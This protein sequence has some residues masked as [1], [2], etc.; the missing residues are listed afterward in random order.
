[1]G[2]NDL[3]AHFMNEG[4]ALYFPC[5][6][7]NTS[8]ISHAGPKADIDLD[9]KY[10]KAGKSANLSVKEENMYA[11]A[12]ALWDV[13]K[14]IGP[15]VLDP[16]IVKSWR[17]MPV[18]KSGDFVVDAMVALVQADKQMYHGEHNQTIISVF[19]KHNIIC[20]TCK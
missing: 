20:K 19:A 18:Q 12:E 9:Y 14:E 2:A 6:Y 10:V 7:F 8:Y 17:I 4:Y 13:R 3:T 1:M 16:M 15:E 11:F 5:S